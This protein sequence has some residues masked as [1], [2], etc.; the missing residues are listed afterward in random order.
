MTACEQFAAARMGLSANL[1]KF[2]GEASMIKIHKDIVQGCMAEFAVYNYLQSKGL[3]CTKPDLS[4]HG[5]GQKSFSADL[6]SGSNLL[7]VKSQ[8]IESAL[9]YSDSWIFQQEDSVLSLP[10][11]NGYAFFCVVSDNVVYIKAAVYIIEMLEADVVSSPKV[12]KYARY[13]SAIYLSELINKNV[14]LRRF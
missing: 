10:S 12:G 11:E 14:N 1:Y 7:H 6:Q 3:P 8:S 5:N 9:K 2:R 13:K 4:I